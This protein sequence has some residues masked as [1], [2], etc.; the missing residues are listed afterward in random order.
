MGP[1]GI[2]GQPAQR[3]ATIVDVSAIP[4]VSAAPSYANGL[5][6]TG[7]ATSLEALRAALDAAALSDAAA[8][9]V[10]RELS[11]HLGRV[12]TTQ[13]RAVGTW[14]GNLALAAGVAPGASAFPSDVLL[15]L[16]AAGAHVVYLPRNATTQPAT[17]PTVTVVEYV[18]TESRDILVS[19]VLPL[20]PPSPPA[21]ST[22]AYLDK[23][24]VRHAN[25]HAIVNAGFVLSVR[26][27]GTVASGVAAFGGVLSS[28]L[29]LPFA[30]T[31]TSLVGKSLTSEADLRAWVANLQAA[32]KA[33]GMAADDGSAHAAYRLSLMS[34]FAYK[35]FLK[36]QP[37]LPPKLASAVATSLA[38]IADRPTS[39]GAPNV[40]GSGNPKLAPVGQPIPKLTARLQA[41]AE[42]RYPSDETADRMV[43][44]AF[45][46]TSGGTAG[47]LLTSI[48]STAALACPG[49]L[50]ILAASDLPFPAANRGIGPISA[51]TPS[52]L[53]AIGDAV[54]C[55]G[56][57]VAV[58]VADTLQ[59]ARYAAKHVRLSY[60]ARDPAAVARA[61]EEIQ[62]QAEAEAA[63]EREGTQSDDLPPSYEQ[64]M[65]VHQTV[66][67]QQ[68]IRA[69]AKGCANSSTRVSKEGFR[70]AVNGLVR[71]GVAGRMRVPVAALEL[72]TAAAAAAASASRASTAVVAKAEAAAA[73]EAEPHHHWCVSA[74]EETDGKAQNADSRSSVQLSG[75]FNTGGQAHFFLE[76]H[77]ALAVPL[78]DERILLWSSTQDP[79]LTQRAVASM[80]GV[81]A[82]RVD[83]RVRR[84]GG[85]YGGKL[86]GHVPT[87]V[88]AAV[89]A[90]ALGLPVKLHNE[91][92]DDMTSAGGRS[93]LEAT[94]KATCEAD[95][96]ISSLELVMDFDSGCVPNSGAGDLG[97]AIK[98]SDCC[99]YHKT[100]KA[101]GS[102]NASAK[103]G[104]Q[105]C[106]APGVIQSSCLHE[107]AMDAC[108]EAIGIGKEEIRE[109]NMYTLGQQ[110]PFGVTLGANGFDWL[111]PQ[112]W[113]K[114]KA[115]W[116]VAGR[117]ARIAAYNT[118]NTWRKRG[119][120]MLPLKY[121]VGP[122]LLSMPAAVR[123]YSDGAVSVSRRM[124]DRAGDT[125]QGRPGRRA[126]P[127]LPALVRL[128]L[129]HLH[130]R[131][132]QRRRHRR[133]D[134]IRILRRRRARRLRL[135]QQL[136]RPLPRSREQHERRGGGGW[137][138]GRR[139][140]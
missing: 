62:A 105:S 96:T 131:R 115:S 79:A 19:L 78:E 58:V 110:T 120:S 98:W 123:I 70:E 30:S 22:I 95:G 36:A 121:N 103:V 50:A 35:L 3:C 82:N 122:G 34:S 14:A 28:G 132:S 72:T 140:D 9:T 81:G 7:A 124:R 18:S 12:A 2:G 66:R 47:K 25:S 64:A 4:E 101:T 118:A 6:A 10:A 16:A 33:A 39:S 80:L 44:G 49:V 29:W 129:R 138:S 128:R 135:S 69:D 74:G 136:A 75:T 54:P 90:R 59:H 20:H 111:V 13:I 40:S 104:N 23:V 94:W 85:A 108:A 89:A 32:A 26:S 55:V 77:S 51:T 139:G 116:D 107:F 61:E 43:H 71:S 117:R 125:R 133:L 11:R 91:R 97:M 45:V 42:A 84:A 37:S 63:T 83:V 60:T 46:N 48:E 126:R 76:T 24:S 73:A 27:D 38:A 130:P 114:A 92:V 57:H 88:V 112:L 41:S 8:A 137:G 52:Y 113:A 15:L 31:S 119:L 93:P 65:Q 100:F 86:Q 109:K 21:T 53:L 68:P 99:Y 134:G 17:L 5:L 87:A 56:T 127:R 102:I 106:R 1:T 67:V